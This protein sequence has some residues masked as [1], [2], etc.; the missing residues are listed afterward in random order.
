MG[1]HFDNLDSMEFYILK[2][3]MLGTVATFNATSIVLNLCPNKRVV[4]LAT[5]SSKKTQKKN[6]HR[7]IKIMSK[8]GV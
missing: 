3:N 4:H 7:A 2:L 8:E 6:F 1:E 5:H